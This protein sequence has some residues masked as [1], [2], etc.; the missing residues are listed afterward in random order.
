MRTSGRR[1]AAVAGVVAALAL[2]AG[3][4][5]TSA[6]DRTAT[7]STPLTAAA[8]GSTAPATAT[9]A[10]TSTAPT[11]AAPSTSAP[12]GSMSAYAVATTSRTFE[13]GA[14]GRT[15]PTTIY[16][17]S[18]TPPAAA[19]SVG[20]PVVDATGREAPAPAAFPLVLM[21]H[22]YLL[23]GD[24]YDRIMRAV[25]AHGYVVAAPEFPHSTGHGGDGQRSDIT[26]Q[27]ADL[28]FVADR[29]VELGASGTIT[30]TIADPQRIAVVGHSDGGLTATAFGYGHQYRDLRVAAVVSLTGGVG[31]F[32]G[33]FYA[34]DSPPLLAAHTRD[35]GTNPYTA[36][37][38]LFQG[39]P[40]GRPRFLL[41]IDAGGHIDPFMFGT[42]RFDL[43]DAIADFLDL[44]L[45]NDPEAL[46]RL[47]T[48]AARPGFSL[49]EG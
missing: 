14:R 26:N 5:G 17:P 2:V 13:D 33:A 44:T 20:D 35:D 49:E 37:V 41:T 32:P 34:S 15:L 25:A 45:R 28:A 12:A 36:S 4:C 9:T 16:F 48:T 30:P 6:P 29:M 7:G 3:A 42:A 31:L 21:A 39:V 11:S 19:R 24:G 38:N 23:P 40:A 18:A 22:G 10:P 43:G 47:R 8:T 1:A 27:P 46:V